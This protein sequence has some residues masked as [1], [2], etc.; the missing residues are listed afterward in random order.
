MPAYGQPWAEQPSQK[1]RDEDA[2]P[3]PERAKSQL[4]PACLGNLF[5]RKR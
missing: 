2:Q 4:F 5:G 3:A 1:P